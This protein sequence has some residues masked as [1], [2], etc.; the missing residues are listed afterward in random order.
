MNEFKLTLG[1]HERL[2][3]ESRM[4]KETPET[5]ENIGRSISLTKERIRQ[6]ENK[7]KEKLHRFCIRNN[8]TP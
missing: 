4:L 8:I 6:I 7:I 3:F 5:L 2:I 1:D